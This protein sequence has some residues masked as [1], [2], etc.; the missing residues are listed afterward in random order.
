MI[1]GNLLKVVEAMLKDPELD[2]T[3]V[4]KLLKDQDE[5]VRVF[6][7]KGTDTDHDED[8][9]KTLESLTWRPQG[10]HHLQRGAVKPVLA[11]PKCP[12]M[13]R[14]RCPNTMKLHI[15]HHYLDFWQDKVSRMLLKVPLIGNP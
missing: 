12:K 2:M 15:F 6:L 13:D 8:P 1:F 3:S 10:D 4:L 5:R 7:E 11:C 9:V 14:N